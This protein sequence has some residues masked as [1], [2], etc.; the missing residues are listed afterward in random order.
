M[1][2][3]VAKVHQRDG[4]VWN[5]DC[6][7]F[8][9]DTNRDRK[10]YYQFD[11][12]PIGTVYDGTGVGQKNYNADVQV[13]TS[14]DDKGWTVELAIP[15]KDLCVQVPVEGAKMGYEIA[16]IR[17]RTDSKEFVFQFPPLGKASNH[18]PELFGTL[19]FE[20]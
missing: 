11:I 13:A 18:Q 4:D 14:R 16:R 19:T 17:P 10:M 20:R 1:K 5:D 9:L 15:W 8:F 12:N 6:L 3:L 7:E 2:E